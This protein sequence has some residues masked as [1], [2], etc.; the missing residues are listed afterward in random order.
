MT[1][2]PIKSR[3]GGIAIG[4]ATDC[5]A[6]VA[7]VQALM[8]SNLPDASTLPFVGVITHD[9]Q[10]LGGYSGFKQVGELTAFLDAVEKSPL[11]KAK[12]EVRQQLKELA[13][14]AEAF[15]K[16]GKW[17][18]VIRAAR[19]GSGLFGACPERDALRGAEKKAR[20]WLQGQFDSVIH[21]AV[22]GAKLSNA[23]KRL[24]KVKRVFKG[25]DE[26][27]VAARGILAIKRLNFLRSAEARAN[28]KAG[29]RKG[30]AAEF[31]GTIWVAM[32]GKA[33]A[34]NS[35]KSGGVDGK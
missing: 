18:E 19:T 28:T 26:A 9:G 35:A 32:F 20:D 23:K 24:S 12:P 2:D 15:A 14:S 16:K 31:K 25:E 10:W 4:L 21:D 8:R 33:P 27:A 34:K 11:L 29:L 3:I 30:V 22:T 1:T 17:A 6:S 5:D 7:D 13:A